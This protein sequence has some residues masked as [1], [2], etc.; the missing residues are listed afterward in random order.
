MVA[1]RQAGETPR[2][3]AGAI[4][5]SLE[6]W[7]RLAERGVREVDASC[8][9]AV[10]GKVDGFGFVSGAERLTD[11]GKLRALKAVLR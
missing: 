8:S 7:P 10:A 2:R 6:T 4:A 3:I 1:R 9:V 5:V 11:R